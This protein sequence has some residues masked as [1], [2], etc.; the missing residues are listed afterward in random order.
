[1]E[2]IFEEF[3]NAFLN[4]DFLADVEAAQNGNQTERKEVPVGRYEVKI[5]KMELTK[6]SKGDPMFTCWFKV[7]N[8]DYKGQMIFMNQLVTKGFQ[9][10][11]VNEL[12]RTL[13]SRHDIMFVSYKQWGE[14]IQDVFNDV[15]G[16]L[17]YGLDYSENA[18]G[19]KEFKIFAQFEAAPF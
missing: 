14:L 3:D 15:N 19:F 6:S 1:M 2:H 13:K 4:D 16:R 7:V 17:E 9:V 11:I 10:H 5:N 18:K 12:L 8:G